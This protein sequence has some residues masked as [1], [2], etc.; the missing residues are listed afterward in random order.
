MER[1]E[2]HKLHKLEDSYWWFVGR[3]ELVQA[4][5]EKWIRTDRVG[6]I[7][8]IGCGTGGNLAFLTRWGPATG[9]DISPIAL[10]LARSRRLPYLTQAS[11]LALP[12]ADDTFGLVTLF[13]VLYH[14]WITNDD[15]VV[16][17]C[18]R[19]LQPGGWLMVMDSALPAMWSYHDEVFYA[20]QRYSPGE[21]GRM[22][23]RGR[24]SLHKL[25]YANSLL[26]PVAMVVRLLE[27]RFPSISDA[28][29]K[30]LPGWL[31]QALIGVLKLE[32]KWLRRATFPI[33]SSVICLAQKPETRSKGIPFPNGAYRWE[34][35]I[36]EDAIPIT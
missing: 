8:D 7:L 20:R 11:G 25:S 18:Y 9:V 10:G 17:E 34:R 36:S 22:V 19:I 35:V 13:D 3:R 2:Y 14:R 23:A 31:N 32:A 26:F 4:L 29:L 27:R 15:H 12:Y 1:G 6:P 28:E 16:N 30:P 21:L 5:I 33:G 24:F